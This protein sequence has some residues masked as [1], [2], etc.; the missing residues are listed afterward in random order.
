MG[1]SCNFLQIFKFSCHTLLYSVQRHHNNDG[2][3]RFIHP[4]LKIRK[5][6][7][8][9]T[10]Y[11][12][13]LPVGWNRYACPQAA[14]ACKLTSICTII[15]H[16]AET[17]DLHPSVPPLSTTFTSNRSLLHYYSRKT[18]STWQSLR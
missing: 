10:N 17:Q 13:C 6:T 18:Y 1:C 14:R 7:A 16:G 3:P 12:L 9:G 4:T 11:C 2:D 5:L 8:R 15:V